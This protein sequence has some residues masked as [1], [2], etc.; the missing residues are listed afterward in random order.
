MKSNSDI[1]ISKVIQD[2][3]KM[4]GK[5]V[6]EIGCGDGRISKHLVK[7]VGQLT[8]IDPDTRRIQT[9]K[10]SSAKITFQV[11][12][13]EDP[14]F[15]NNSFDFVIF[16]LSL[17]HQNSRKALSEA[18]RVLR[19]HGKIIVV[20][21]IPEGEV[22][23]VFSFLIDEDQSK[24]DAQKA[25]CDSA[26]N[27]DKEVGFNAEWTFADRK[28]LLESVFEY[29]EMIY[30][31]NIASDVVRFLGPKIEEKPIVLEDLMVLQVLS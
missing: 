16:T 3:I 7:M 23:R 9:A 28:D 17:H 10:G 20:E 27:L 25:I 5:E 21:P 12:S 2:H 14:G 11:G 22:E 6:L 13:G 19:Q 29:Y 15:A 26:L 24:G 8:S 4:V 18:K 31:R 30:D 1:K